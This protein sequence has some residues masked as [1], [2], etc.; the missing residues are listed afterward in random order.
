MLINPPKKSL[1]LP[2]LKTKASSLVAHEKDRKPVPGADEKF[3]EENFLPFEL[4]SNSANLKFCTYREHGKNLANISTPRAILFLTHGLFAHE[5]RYAHIPK[6]FSKLGITTVGF[7]ARGHGKSGGLSG[8]IQNM[9]QLVSDF[10][11]FVERIDK[12]YDKEIPRFYI[13]QS[14]GGMLGFLFGLKK[15]NYFNG[16]M[17]FSPSLK[18]ND[19]NKFAMK[20]AKYISYILGRIPIPLSA[21]NDASRNPAV[22]EHSRTDPFVYKGGIRPTTIASF[23]TAM[24]FTSQNLEK[25]N[26]PFV[27]VQGGMDVTVD[28]ECNIDLVEKSQSKDKT[29]VFYENLW[30]DVMHEQEIYEILEFLGNWVEE[31]IKANYTHNKNIFPNI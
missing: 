6:F 8:Y 17:L 2:F 24:D 15:S 23:V 25:F 14:M 1:N 26:V 22:F 27:L 13:G 4:I 5:N 29:L 7:D 12:I 20:F 21:K 16:M 11:E 28:V 9:D 31:R 19:S 30:H 10:E 3:E 18:M